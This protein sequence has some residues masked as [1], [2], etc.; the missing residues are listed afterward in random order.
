MRF[1]A[2]ALAAMLLLAACGGG[3]EEGADTPEP[4][5]TETTEPTE[6]PA[7]GDEVSIAGFLYGPDPIEVAV[8]T[9]VTWTNTDAAPHTATADD[10]SFDTGMLEEGDS[11]TATFAEAG[12]VPYHCTV[13]P[14]MT[15]TVIVA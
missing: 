9:E 1:G 4:T 8:G 10:G 12:E 15:G 13:H 11:G 7:G 5:E 14:E 3:D 2:A 6:E